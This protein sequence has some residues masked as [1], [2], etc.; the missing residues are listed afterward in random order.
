M[1]TIFSKI[2]KNEILSFKILE[3]NKHLAFLDAFPLKKGH[4]LVIPKKE[5]DYI[6]DIESDEYLELWLFAKKI[7]IAMKK[8]LKCKRIAIAVIGLEVPHAHIH[9]IPMDSVEEINFSLPKLNLSNNQ[10]ND[11][12]ELIKSAI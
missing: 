4:I 3:D 9:L 8:V 11:I 1:S 12:S 2:I 6:F 10:M 7:S 5:I